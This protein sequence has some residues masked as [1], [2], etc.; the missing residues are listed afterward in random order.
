MLASGDTVEA[1]FRGDL[2]H[3]DVLWDGGSH[4][5]KAGFIAEN[6]RTQEVPGGFLGH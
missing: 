1:K 5:V 6:G 3:S 2:E 4:A